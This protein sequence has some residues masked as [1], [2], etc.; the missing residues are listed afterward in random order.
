MM[1]V[2]VLTIVSFPYVF[3]LKN[4]EKTQD[5]YNIENNFFFFI[6]LTNNE[7][8]GQTIGKRGKC[9]QCYTCN[10]C[11]SVKESRK[12]GEIEYQT[13]TATSFTKEC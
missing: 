1:D 4:D 8:L 10:S 2:C 11:R 9:C 6:D 7:K 13:K 5:G 3:D 12:Y